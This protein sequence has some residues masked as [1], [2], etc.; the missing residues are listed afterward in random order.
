[1][2]P[3][4]EVKANK[5]DPMKRTPAIIALALILGSA[6]SAASAVPQIRHISPELQKAVA[7][8]DYAG[9]RIKTF[10]FAA[11]AWTFRKFTF[12]ETVQKLKELGVGAVE[13][14]DGQALSAEIPG[15]M[16]GA[17]MTP[18]QMAKVKDWLK[19][20]GVTLYGYGVV[21][22]GETEASMRKVF[23]FARKM[24]IRVV[25]CE[26]ADDDFTLLEKLVKEYDL[27][28][29]IHNHPAPS[30][31]N[32]PETVFSHVT[33]K[34][35]RIGACADNGHWMRGMNE[36]REAFKLLQGRILDVHLKDRS[37]FGM[38]KGVDDVPW[39]AGKGMIRDLLAELTL[40]DYDGYLTME[41]ENE[42]EVGDPM[43]AFRK[44]I[45]Y[46]KSVTYYEG[47]DQILKRGWGGY[48]KYGWNHYGPGYFECDPKTGVLKGQGG[49]GLLW[50]SKK[51][52]DFILEC[53]FK[54]ST[55]TTNSGIFLR[56]PS[57]P[58]SDD[59][60]YHS[61]EIQIDDKSTGIH[62]TGAAYD[63]EAPKVLASL[64]TGE[65]NHF[66][67]EFIG[68]HL[69]IELNGKLVMD[70]D[71]KPGGKVRDLSPEGY[72]GLQNHDSQ[73]PPYFRNVY[74]KEL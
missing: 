14:Y 47:Y 4:V 11:E 16:F 53:D 62:H 61:I 7:A 21:D 3:E 23:D 36:S 40:Q 10:P 28:I 74:I 32:L 6:A 26:P 60:I 20:A 70:W 63:I 54:C 18:D 39:G 37:D 66:K 41:Y 25:V 15:A 33:G 64:P 24:G 38:A 19:A 42:S 50:Y 34:D 27:K 49:M 48:E 72:I 45:A 69:K 5:G 56:V 17:D 71:A 57:V 52:R 8:T 30:K 58:V 44:S 67:I 65:W 68:S 1:M 12:F 59:Y 31:Y 46:V 22:I 13:A 35:A 55:E 51:V 43:P 73:S 9:V 2:E 29:A